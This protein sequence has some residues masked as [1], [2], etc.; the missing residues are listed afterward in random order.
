MSKIIAREEPVGAGLDDDI[1]CRWAAE[2]YRDR[3]DRA[4][5]KPT[6]AEWARIV[7]GRELL[8]NS[9]DDLR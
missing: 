2:H 1:K 3:P 7:R 6:A 8:A 4:D 9:N 5:F